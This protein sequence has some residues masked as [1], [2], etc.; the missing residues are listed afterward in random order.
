MLLH[1]IEVLF[2]K[3]NKGFYIGGLTKTREKAI[4][5]AKQ[6]ETSSPE[7]SFKYKTCSEILIEF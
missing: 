4:M 1:V 2:L 3:L 7:L 5:Q 6:D